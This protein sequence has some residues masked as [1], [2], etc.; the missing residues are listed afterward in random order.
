MG[1]C[2]STD[3][4]TATV[5][6]A[7]S[8]GPPTHKPSPSS[9]A[10]SK[11]QTASNATVADKEKD[12]VPT[13]AIEGSPS[14]DQNRSLERTAS[15]DITHIIGDLSDSSGARESLAVGDADDPLELGK[16]VSPLTPSNDDDIAAT[17]ELEPRTSTT[18][19]ETNKK[20]DAT[21][22]DHEPIPEEEEKP[23]EPALNSNVEPDTVELAPISNLSATTTSERNATTS[24]ATESTP[25]PDTEPTPATEDTQDQADTEPPKEKESPAVRTGLA[26]M[27]AAAK[28][29]DD[30]S[31]DDA[32]N[33]MEVP[34]VAKPPSPPTVSGGGGLA[35]MAAARKAMQES[36]SP[37]TT[38][39]TPIPEQ[40]T[41]SSKDEAAASGGL[42]AMAARAATARV[43]ESPSPSA[44]GNVAA[45]GGL[46]SMAAMAA[47]RRASQSPLPTTTNP[48]PEQISG[49]PGEVVNSGGGLA[50]MAATA[51]A[52]TNIE[53]PPTT[54]TTAADAGSEPDTVATAKPE[55]TMPISGLPAIASKDAQEGKTS[56]MPEISPTS[57]TSQAAGGGSMLAMMAAKA[58]ERRKQQEEAAMAPTTE[59]GEPEEHSIMSMDQDVENE[60][61]ANYDSAVLSSSNFGFGDEDIVSDGFDEEDV[62]P[63]DEA[64]LMLLGD[65]EEDE[66][67]NWMGLDPPPTE[68]SEMI[69]TKINFLRDNDDISM[70]DAGGAVEELDPPDA[71]VDDD[72]FGMELE[73]DEADYED[74]E[75]SDAMETDV[76][77][78]LDPLE[79]TTH[80]LELENS[81]H[82]NVGMRAV[83]Y[84]STVDELDPPQRDEFGDDDQTELPEKYRYD[85]D[86]H[87]GEG[88]ESTKMSY[89]LAQ[90]DDAETVDIVDPST[91]ASTLAKDATSE[92]VRHDE[93]P[94]DAI[95]E[96]DPPS[97]AEVETTPT[98]ESNE[99]DRDG[100]VDEAPRKKFARRA[101]E[102]WNLD[103]STRS[104]LVESRNDEED[105][106]QNKKRAMAALVSKE[107][108]AALDVVLGRRNR[109]TYHQPSLDDEILTRNI[110]STYYQP[111]LDE[112][113]TRIISRSTYKD[114]VGDLSH[115]SVEGRRALYIHFSK[116]STVAAT[117]IE[118]DELS[119]LE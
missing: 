106:A 42:A 10:P 99:T 64:E 116:P 89:V 115:R 60:D 82:C 56:K 75:G 81:V 92:D 47:A 40:T 70:E 3:T 17:E 63:L 58:A 119:D 1:A 20:D 90:L 4:S 111:S 25:K 93:E 91:L 48:T 103:A 18:A 53:S 6:G 72:S 85:M 101:S 110:R 104:Y 7:H 109:S 37:A 14:E 80:T 62:G 74:E 32:A 19:E 38:T 15:D 86:T 105:C 46:A 69:T 2:C 24:S 8:K 76:D 54:E 11:V 51:A 9:S 27:A 33:G 31:A 13:N 12:K 5:G 102:P 21:T 34:T 35:A 112:V 98:Q 77:D 45:G 117:A 108:E 84:Y 29:V 49:R 68:D 16:S 23:T 79:G 118:D 22:N 83:Q 66:E 113:M 65:K 41:E 95:D 26:A 50:A 55:E 88:D 71:V 39:T 43:A 52:S 36:P 78:D 67:G 28:K 30:T 114:P 97:V 87:N 107:D 57:V 100:A 59:T 44:S 61:D 96:L 94:S 73:D